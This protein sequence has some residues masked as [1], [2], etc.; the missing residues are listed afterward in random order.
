M[1]KF[2][3]SLGA[4]ALAL[5]GVAMA[6]PPVHHQHFAADL[7]AHDAEAYAVEWHSRPG[8]LGNH[9]AHTIAAMKSPYVNLD[10]RGLRQEAAFGNADAEAA[11]GLYHLTATGVDYDPVAAFAYNSAAAEEGIP[12]AATNL[13]LQYLNGVG[14]LRDT[15]KAAHWFEVAA[16]RGHT[17]AAYQTGVMYLEGEGVPSN[18]VLA[19]QWLLKAREAG[20]A[21]AERLLKTFASF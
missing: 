19:R 12:V 8:S 7:V 17:A 14:T 5:T 2:G 21:R 10:L 3:F 13:G 4:A 16:K 11:L 15:E 1:R 20:D 9:A 18:D 6:Q